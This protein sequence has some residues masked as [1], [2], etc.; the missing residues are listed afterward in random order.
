MQICNK[1]TL[2][3]LVLMCGSVVFGAT[4]SYSSATIQYIKIEFG[5]LSLFEVAAFQSI[6]SM[7]AIF[8]PFLFN[9]FL[10]HYRRKVVSSFLG[11][12]GA[13]FWG[14]LLLMNKNYFW[15][16]ILIRGLHGIILAGVSLICPMYI[17]ELSPDD[18]H[19]FFGTLNTIAISIGHVIY[20]LLG[21]THNWKYP[22]Y[23]TIGFLLIYGSFIWLIPD[24]PSD[25]K[26][27]QH[28]QKL[29]LP[30]K[31]NK[32]EQTNQLNVVN[33]NA[34]ESQEELNNLYDDD[35]IDSKI[36]AI[37]KHDQNNV[38]ELNLRA[39]SI[40]QRKFLKPI[41][42]SIGMMCFLQLSGIGAI[43]TNVAPLM[44][45]AGLSFDP[46]FQAAIATSA[47]LFACLASSLIMDRFGRRK[48]WIFSSFGS[49]AS[50][51]VYALNIKLDW[52]KWLPMA[53]LFSYLLFFGLGMASLP[54]FL[55]PEM[56]PDSVRSVGMTIA[57]ADNWLSASIA[58][59]LFPY[60]KKW[61][62]QFGLMLILMGIC[63]LCGIFGI[64]FVKDSI[65]WKE[66]NEPNIEANLINDQDALDI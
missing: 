22:I 23:M 57:T 12:I 14:L 6:P 15:L 31:D 21:V 30:V 39:E 42:L 24:S 5:P 56:F 20:N 58:T 28:N 8:S 40:F 62:G 27:Q 61:L 4:I 48:M 36:R 45:E 60:I 18:S 33:K 59:F 1:T 52:S 2:Y 11:L 63:T 65:I 50:L 17:I 26:I 55:V 49:A 16:A 34:E 7:V 29:K 46:G 13:I 25:I 43:I 54:W 10:T 66:E 51:L 32:K 19:G 3:A 53:S 41:L 9:Y 47:Q 64:A 44:S 37:N 35:N 38:K